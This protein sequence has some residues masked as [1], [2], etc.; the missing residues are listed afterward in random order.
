[1][2]VYSLI[3]REISK[4]FGYRGDSSPSV[5]F[6]HKEHWPGLESSPFSFKCGKWTLRGYKY[7]QNDLKPKA[8]V[9]FYH[10][11]STGHYGYLN[12]IAYLAKHGYLVYA[13]DEKGSVLSEGNVIGNLAEA[14][15]GQKPFYEFLKTQDDIKGLPLYSVGHSW[16]GYAALCSLRFPEVDK[17]VSIAGFDSPLKVC[18]DNAPILKYFGWEFC[19]YQFFHYGKNGNVSGLKLM[20]KTDKPVFYMQ[21]DKDTMV[22]YQTSGK[23]FME[24]L[25]DKPNIKFYIKENSHHNPYWSRETEDYYDNHVKGPAWS[26]S[27]DRNLDLKLDYDKLFSI[28]E[29]FM[30]RVIDFLEA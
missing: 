24:V 11:I 2:I 16:G 21:G 6:A 13:Y 5:D 19:I 29:D 7:W 30:R 4:N 22:N 27:Y 14:A 25:K 8:V 12:V 10:G 15:K 9:V 23:R 1:M 3:G 17:V 28:E 18:L 20:Q 26:S